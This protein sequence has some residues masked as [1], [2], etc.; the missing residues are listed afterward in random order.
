MAATPPA[1][2]VQYTLSLPSEDAARAAA[3][4]LSGIG[5]R[6]T[7]VRVQDH[8]RFVPS[9]F[10]YGKPSMDPELEGWWQVFSLAVY[11]GYE[12]MALEPF[13]RSE[14]IRVARVARAHGGFQQGGSEGH[15]ET[16]EGVFTRDGLVH[17]QAGADVVLPSPLPK[18]PVRPPA[19]PPWKSSEV[20]EPAVLVQAV[21]AVA[22]RMYGGAED[23]PD[24][25][26]WLLDEEFAFGEPYGSTGEFLGD[27]ADAVAHQG[28]CTDATVE[29]VPFLMELVC[30][31]NVAPGS[32]LVLLGDLLRLAASGPAAAVSLA[33]RITAL[34]G[35]WEESAAEY[36]TRRAIGSDLPRLLSRW[37]DED[38]AIRF[39]LAA[40]AALCGTRD[41]RVL[42][43]LDALPA[44]AGSSRADVVS[45][46]AALLRDDLEGLAPAL[47]RLG[48]WL[49][50]VAEKAA[51]PSVDLQSLGLAILPDL[52]LE[53]VASGIAV[54]RDLP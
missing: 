49:P 39:A 36:L 13:F 38:D 19:G 12:R 28:T 3:A 30:Y 15:A 34:G 23:V 33:D 8:F 9:S 54:G 26:G 47:D 48:S 1:W 45:L 53:D 31:D 37:E 42:P 5:H 29:A 14:W 52:V 10:W 22:E 50:R 32:R 4:E 18:D 27:L 35:A 20:G 51:S 11:S 41:Q 24:A 7:A 17:E 46:M 2:G 21:V 25:V 40:L 6:L 43:G 44:P 16:L